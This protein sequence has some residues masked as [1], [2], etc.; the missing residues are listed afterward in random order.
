MEQQVEGPD[1]HTISTSPG[2]NIVILSGIEGETLSFPT[3]S[4]SST[5]VQLYHEDEGTQFCSLVDLMGDSHLRPPDVS[6]L[7]VEKW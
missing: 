6:R 7:F 5:I 1:A 4:G 3:S 2:S